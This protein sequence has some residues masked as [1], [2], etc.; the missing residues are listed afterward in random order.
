MPTCSFSH[1]LKNFLLL[2][3]QCWGMPGSNKSNRLEEWPVFI[4][5]L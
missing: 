4:E 1:R 5:E 3:K 2:E